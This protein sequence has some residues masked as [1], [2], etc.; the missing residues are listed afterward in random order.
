M[1]HPYVD[2]I[3]VAVSRVRP[4][5]PELSNLSWTG[6][7]KRKCLAAQSPK[8]ASPKESVVQPPINPQ[9]LRTGGLITHS[10]SRKLI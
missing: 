4:C 1:D 5:Y 9:P 8:P 7:K 6:S 10:M 3:F 2:L